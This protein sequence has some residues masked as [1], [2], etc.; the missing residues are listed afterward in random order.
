SSGTYFGDRGTVWR[1]ARAALSIRGNEGVN[2]HLQRGGNEELQEAT[3]TLALY[4]T[5]AAK[6]EAHCSHLL[7]SPENAL[8]RPHRLRCGRAFGFTGAVCKA[9]TLY[10]RSR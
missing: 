8:P 10:T 5:S 2:V 9:S 4:L 6:C 3:S 1:Q 7:A